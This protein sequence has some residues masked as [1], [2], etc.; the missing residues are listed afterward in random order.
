MRNL[1]VIAVV[2]LVVVLAS[3]LAVPALATNLMIEI[4]G[5]ATAGDLFVKVDDQKEVKVT[6]TAGQAIKAIRDAVV[7]ALN[8]QKAGTAEPIGDRML[9]RADKEI[10]IGEAA[11]SLKP[12]AFEVDSNVQARGLTFKVISLPTLTEWGLITLGLL[13]AGSM[14]FVLYRRRSALRPVAP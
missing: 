6:L 4:S 1:K 7:K 2:G 13:L 8:D 3:W 5:T 10:K 12:L 14:A 9:I 11:A